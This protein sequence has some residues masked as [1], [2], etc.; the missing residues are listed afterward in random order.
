MNISVILDYFK[1]F[2]PFSLAKSENKYNF[3]TQRNRFD[4]FGINDLIKFKY[5]SSKRV[6]FPDLLG[7]P[8]HYFKAVKL[9]KAIPPKIE[10]NLLAAL[11]ENFFQRCFEKNNTELLIS[12][13]VTG[14]ERCGLFIARKLGIKTLCVWEGFFRPSTISYDR[15][16][17]NAESEF[18]L[19]LWSEIESHVSS[20]RFVDFY[21]YYTSNVKRNPSKKANL[22]DIQKGK[23]DFLHQLRNR[24]LDRSDIERIRLPIKE[25]FVAR[26]SYFTY[27]NKYFR[28]SEIDEP[29]IFFPLQTHTDSNIVINSMLF[30]YEKYVELVQ[31]YFLEI[32]KRIKCNLIIKE[33]PFDVLR[34]KYFR[35][36]SSS[37]KWLDPA[38]S[39]DKVLN[40]ELCKG[41]ILV[42]STA[43]LE[44]LIFGKPVLTMGKAIYSRPELSLNLDNHSKEEFNQKIISLIE[45]KVDMN[46]VKI[47]CACL[48]DSI[49]FEGNIDNEPE[50]SEIFMFEDLFKKIS[51]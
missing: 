21:N 29:F 38:V 44:S 13:G 17:M 39:T 40:H 14:F 7:N 24:F 23:F 16:G 1:Y 36:E 42:N 3:I 30:P 35:K 11:Y 12:G 41:T 2:I 9:L 27:K 4:S 50:L 32:Q 31:K 34:K 33:H 46:A 20:K 26:I 51:V 18:N 49:Q 10:I 15:L 6:S 22:R 25:H 45:N 19:K 37:I 48:F 28:I 47:F 43:G 5:E 8:N